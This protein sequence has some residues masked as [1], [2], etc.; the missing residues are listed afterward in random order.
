MDEFKR[1]KIV[2]CKAKPDYILWVQFDDGIEG[3][4]DLSDLVGL[5]VF[6]A[7]E[8]KEFFETVKIDPE[9]ETVCW[10][11]EIDLDPYV[12]KQEI[13]DAQKKMD[14]SKS[15]ETDTSAEK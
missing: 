7:W 4:I 8:S 1:A 2:S 3:E 12:I 14:K 11:E 13:I 15:S 5:G 10:G 6:K 9:S